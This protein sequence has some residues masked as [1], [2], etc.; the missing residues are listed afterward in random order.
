MSLPNFLCIGTQRGG[1]TW[2]YE[3]LRV[4]PDIYLPVQKEIHFFNN[5]SNYDKGIDWYEKTFF[6]NTE[7]KKIIGEITPAYLYIESAAQRIYKNLGKDIKLIIM[8]RNPAE[9]AFSD[10]WMEYFRGNETLSFEEA[11]LMEPYRICRSYEEKLYYSYIKRGFYYAQIKNYFG[12]YP[13]GNIKIL[14]FEEF[15]KDIPNNLN[16]VLQFLN[17]PLMKIDLKK[18]KLNATVLNCKKYYKAAYLN[19]SSVKFKDLIFRR[20]NYPSLNTRYQ[21]MLKRLYLNDIK[22][23]QELLNKNFSL[24]L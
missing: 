5:D 10:Y 16:D 21:K 15:F 23:L 4:H 1:T 7:G 9:R 3:M 24:W 22:N 20:P 6:S 11:I 12:F 2:L 13:S 18:S 14:I 8:L 19:R 17:C